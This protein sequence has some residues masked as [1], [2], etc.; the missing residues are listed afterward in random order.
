MLDI[1]ALERAVDRL[2][3]GLVRYR[4]DVSDTQI[5]DGL[6]QRFEFTYELSH[7][8]LKRYLTAVSPTPDEYQQMT[9][10]DLIRSANDRGLLR[11]DWPTWRKFRELRGKTSHTYDEETALQ[12]VAGIPQFLTEAVYLRD[13]LR[14]RLP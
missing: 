10:Q 1:S 13:Q 12:V 4:L 14:Q 11:S 8:T 2:Q 6:I 9:F 5:R 7:K 3:E